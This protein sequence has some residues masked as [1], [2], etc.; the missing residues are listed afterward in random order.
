M[1]SI[2]FSPCSL[3]ESVVTARQ[4]KLRDLTTELKEVKPDWHELGT[5]LDIPHDEL[6]QIE[7]DHPYISRKFNEMLHYWLCNENEPSWNKIIEALDRMGC[8]KKLVQQ[9]KTKY[10]S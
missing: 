10:L 1:C 4:P 8:Y 2:N 5:Q 9:L 6:K 3:T 7:T